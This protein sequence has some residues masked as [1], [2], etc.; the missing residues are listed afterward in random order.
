MKEKT[1]IIITLIFIIV[2]SILFGI[3]INTNGHPLAADT[4]GLGTLGD[5]VGGLLNPTMTFITI[6]FL[7]HTISQNQTIIEQGKEVLSLNTQE[8][9]DT[10]E[11]LKQTKEAHQELTKIENINLTNKELTNERSLYEQE[12][13]TIRNEIDKLLNMNDVK[14]ENIQQKISLNDYTKNYSAIKLNRSTDTDIA[15]LILR[16]V[17]IKSKILCDK[18]PGERLNNDPFKNTLVSIQ[19][20]KCGI[21]LLH[22]A[23]I[24][25]T[26]QTRDT[27][28]DIYEYTFLKDEDRSFKS[29]I[30]N[31]EISFHGNNISPFSGALY[32]KKRVPEPS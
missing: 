27:G 1:N 21:L 18:I 7:I 3:Y 15:I 30:D 22:V 26:V 4:T 20:S 10:R 25:T 19:K 31:F 12:I 23:M 6:M 28:H 29:L 16:E 5:F 32:K 13:N 8:L 17:L 9:S 2:L 24:C 14:L 11:E